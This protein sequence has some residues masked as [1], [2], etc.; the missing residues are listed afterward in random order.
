[1]RNI[2]SVLGFDA[3]RNEFDLKRVDERE[4]TARRLK[5]WTDKKYNSAFTSGGT[6]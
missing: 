6:K 1:V 4:K 5:R 2:T 3:I